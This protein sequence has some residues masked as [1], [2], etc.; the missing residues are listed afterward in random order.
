LPLVGSLVEVLWNYHRLHDWTAS[1][2]KDSPTLQVDFPDFTITYTVLP[3]NVE[4]ILKN[5]FP[6]YPKGEVFQE[7]F[8]S[9]LGDG[10]FNTDG[11][12]WRKQRKIASFEFASK[13]LRDFST[14]VF[15]AYSLKLAVILTHAATLQNT[16]DM[17]DLFLR[18]TMETICQVSFGIGIGTLEPSLPDIPFA[19]AF[20]NAN[21]LSAHR[22]V[23]PLWK[24]KRFFNVGAEATMVKSIKQIDDFAYDVIYARK[25]EV[26]AQKKCGDAKPGESQAVMVRRDFFTRLLLLNEDSGKETFTDKEFR[27]TMINFLMAGR[28]TSASTISWFVSMMILHPEVDKRIEEELRAFEK[29]RKEETDYNVG[30]IKD[31]KQFIAGLCNGADD[32]TSFN[33]QVAEYAQ[34]LTYDSLLKL[35]Y[36]YAAIL[37]TLRLHPPV[38]VDIKGVLND[39]TFPDGTH[40]KKGSLVAYSPWAM[41]RMQYIWGSDACDFKPERWMKDGVVQLES[42]F[43]FTAFQAGPR[44]C[45]GKDSALLQLRMVLAILCRFYK[46]HLVPGAIIKY[47]QMMSLQLANGLPVTITLK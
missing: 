14:E 37:E 8:Q 12:L 45:L 22:F 10:I 4:H 16:T 35:Q 6:N 47:R 26:A 46:F 31:L 5:N 21:E 38:P 30:P 27:D 9:L 17:Q 29:A 33:L 11:E 1:Y 41:G 40:V 43:K 32:E 34:L 24:L 42:P 20:E 44:I 28:D 15:R 36:L 19:K 2:L 25:Q 3:E 39:D 13:V 7:I 23:D 18:L